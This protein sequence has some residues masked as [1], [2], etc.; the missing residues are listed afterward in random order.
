MEEAGGTGDEDEPRVAKKA[1]KKAA[2]RPRAKKQRYACSSPFHLPL[3]AKCYLPT[4]RKTN[5]T[6]AAEDAAEGTPAKLTQ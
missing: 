2:K 1:M 3:V 6:R 4:H 5:T